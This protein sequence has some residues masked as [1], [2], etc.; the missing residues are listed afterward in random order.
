MTTRTHKEFLN[1]LKSRFGSDP[2]RWAFKCPACKDI[3]TGADFL[4]AAK[5][6]GIG[7][8]GTYASAR[9]GQECIGRTLGAL[10]T[11]QGKEYRGRG[12]DWAAYGLF[13]GP[14][15][16]EIPNGDGTTRKVPTFEI[17]TG[18]EVAK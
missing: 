10:S 6:R 1:E 11:D 4:K 7:D 15:F 8:P 14:D 12:C 18:E 16:V 9:L 5:E 13:S 3:A 2:M 17:A